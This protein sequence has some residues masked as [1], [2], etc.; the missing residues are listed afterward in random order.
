MARVWPGF[1]QGLAR[2]WP[3]FGQ[4]LARVWPGFGQRLASVW[5]AFGQRLASGFDEFKGKNYSYKEPNT[6]DSNNTR[7]HPEAEGKQ[8]MG[9]VIAN[10][11]TV[12]RAMSKF[13]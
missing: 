4:R 13:P 2:V 5:P 10:Q 11:M 7:F 1:G 6:L 12:E 9:P 3:G 8:P